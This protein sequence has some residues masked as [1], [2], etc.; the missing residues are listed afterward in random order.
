MIYYGPSARG[1]PFLQI[2]F[3]DMFDIAGSKD[4]RRVSLLTGKCLGGNI[5]IELISLN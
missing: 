3:D 4:A 1:G 5:S 2:Y